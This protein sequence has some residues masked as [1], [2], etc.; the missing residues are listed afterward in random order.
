[1]KNMEESS[2]QPSN[3]MKVMGDSEKYDASCFSDR[4]LDSQAVHD[5]VRRTDYSP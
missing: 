1:M 4:K 5:V 2:V 3:P